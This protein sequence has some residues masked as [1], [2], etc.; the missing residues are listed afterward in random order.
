VSRSWD[1]PGRGR[2]DASRRPPAGRGNPALGHQTCQVRWD[3]WA[4]LYRRSHETREGLR[5]DL[6]SSLKVA[7]DISCQAAYTMEQMMA[8]HLAEDEGQNP[9]DS[10]EE[11]WYRSLWGHGSDQD[12]KIPEAGGD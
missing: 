9:S 6:L 10:S 8:R 3:R 1:L 12:P 4:I 7:G 11:R 2:R 5:I